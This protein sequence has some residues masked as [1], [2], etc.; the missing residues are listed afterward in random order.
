MKHESLVVSA[1]LF[2][3]VTKTFCYAA[4]RVVYNGFSMHG[5]AMNDL[6]V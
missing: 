5:S 3:L 4:L 1:A 2:V 6:L